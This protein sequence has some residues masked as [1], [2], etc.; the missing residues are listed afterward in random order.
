MTSSIFSR[1]SHAVVFSLLLGVVLPAALGQPSVQGQWTTLSNTLPINPVHVALLG[2]GKVLVVA[3]S[4]NCPPSQSGC[5]SGPPYG[6]S[7]GSG[8]LLVDPV[9]GQIISQISLSWDMFCN[10][11][12][13]LPDGRALIDGGTIQYDPFHGQPQVA[14][15]DPATSTFSNT[16][17]MAHGRWYPR[18]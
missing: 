6:P 18:L 2:N 5:P 11:M 16:Q 17:N 13:L 14:I 1:L 9:S 7:N 10:G 8:A 12:V 3:G 15:F 4:G